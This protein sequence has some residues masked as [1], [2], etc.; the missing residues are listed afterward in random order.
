MDPQRM[1]VRLAVV[2]IGLLMA[3]FGVGRNRSESVGTHAKLGTSGPDIPI[4][5]RGARFQRCLHAP[6]DAEAI[7]RRRPDGQVR[8]SRSRVWRDAGTDLVGQIRANAGTN[9]EFTSHHYVERVGL[10]GYSIV[11]RFGSTLT[12]GIITRG[13]SP[14]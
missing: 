12:V 3:D 9:I 13:D 7:A 10:S 2:A 6:S 14:I 1:Q 4:R 5:R 8:G 11:G